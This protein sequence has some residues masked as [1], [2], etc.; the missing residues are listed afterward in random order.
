MH[1]EGKAGS[2]SG[3]L[4]LTLFDGRRAFEIFSVS[5][6]TIRLDRLEVNT[7][8]RERIKM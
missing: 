2:T 1:E 5:V 6:P 3:K 4:S 7:E 8:L